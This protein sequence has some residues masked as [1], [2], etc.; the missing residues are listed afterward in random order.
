MFSFVRDNPEIVSAWI[1]R[2]AA[3]PI[4]PGDADI[5]LQRIDMIAVHDT[6][7]RLR[8]IGQPT[9]VL[10]GAH[11]FCTPPP[12]SKEIESGIPDAELVALARGHFVEHELEDRPRI[13]MT[14][15]VEARDPRPTRAGRHPC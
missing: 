15:A 7:P 12:L 10:C 6:L 1:E 4:R 13:R 8:H 3:I 14:P 9:L 11:D 2:A 5:A